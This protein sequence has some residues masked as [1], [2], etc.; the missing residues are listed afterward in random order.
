MPPPTSGFSELKPRARKPCLNCR[1]SKSKCTPTYL[2]PSCERCRRK[3]LYCDFEPEREPSPEGPL[4]TNALGLIFP[5]PTSPP[6]PLQ[7]LSSSAS[8]PVNSYRVSLSTTTPNPLPYT[9][10]PPQN[11]RPRYSDAK[12]YPDLALPPSSRVGAGFIHHNGVGAPSPLT[13]A[14]AQDYPGPPQPIYYQST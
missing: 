10:P 5:S 1:D 2:P 14:T 3:H 4:S 8:T 9:R 7:F 12:S 6:P 13:P 11:M